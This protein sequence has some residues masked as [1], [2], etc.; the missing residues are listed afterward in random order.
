MTPR[1]QLI[2]RTIANTSTRTQSERR[3]P[4][5]PSHLSCARKA[6]SEIPGNSEAPLCLS[7]QVQ[8][9]CIFTSISPSLSLRQCPDCYAFR[10]G[11][12]LPD[13]KFCYLRT[14]IVTASVHR[15]FG[16]RLPCHQVTNFQHLPALGRHQPP[17]MVLRVCGDMCFWQIVTRA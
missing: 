17:Y 5:S 7:I 11:R 15:G 10:A 4:S 9:V 6:Q 8:V 3:G 1:R 14:V 16:H 12:S 2:S 13:K